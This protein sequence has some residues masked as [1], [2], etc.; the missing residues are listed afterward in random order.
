M[1]R[2]IITILLAALLALTSVP[3]PTFAASETVQVGTVV[4][5]RKNVNVRTRTSADAALLG[6]ADKGN[7]YTVLEKTSGWYK[8]LFNGQIGYIKSDYLSVKKVKTA[9]SKDATLKVGS[10]NVHALGGGKKVDEVAKL[11]HA[12]KLD[13]IGL[14][15]VDWLA[16]RSGRE[17]WPQILAEK[18]G[19]P[20]YYFSPILNMSGGK[21]GTL[22][23]SKQPILYAETMSLSVARGTE[24]RA[25]GYVQLL[26]SK[27]V[28]H[29]F[30]THTSNGSES[31][32]AVCFRAINDKIK[33]KGLS[34][35]FITG[36]F[37]A[38]PEVLARYLP[39]GVRLANEKLPTFGSGGNG[40]AIDN[41]VHTSNVKVSKLKVTDAIG[42]RIS[43]HNLLTATVKIPRK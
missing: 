43:D 13:V 33:A 28:V 9:L 41:I 4:N 37:N 29:M 20:Y 24:A 27:G 6:V 18:A 42:P 39:K 14:Q 5:V 38:S 31:Q 8:V 16:P 1:K 12:A 15:E 23:L 10:F 36:D 22:I 32:K 3:L 17:D 7:K 26:T 2:R 30:N 19:F 25:L 11:I 34:A 21:Y 40:R 35:Y